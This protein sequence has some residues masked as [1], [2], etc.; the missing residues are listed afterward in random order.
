MRV[1]IKYLSL[2]VL[3]LGALVALLGCSEPGGYHPE[4]GDIVFQMSRSSQSLAIQ[5][6]TGS[7]YSHIG[8]VFVTN[9]EP[10]VLEAAR[11]V[12][13]KPLAGWIAQ[14]ENS[15]FVAK[16]LSA[17]DRILTA[18]TLEQMQE[19]GRSFEGRPY[20]MYFEWSDDSLYCS[21]LIWKIYSRCTGLEIGELQKMGELNLSD[22]LVKAK[23]VERF[24]EDLALN[25]TVI[26]PAA[27]FRSDL[28]KTVY[29]Q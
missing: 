12:S 19:L 29:E 28:L 11:T 2:L 3:A 4:D 16:R 26:S 13:L 10:Y 17:A 20:D 8:M 21:E 22:P 5:R 15:H 24:G 1:K 23:L 7:Q 25:E 9:G 18:A 27:M 6:A 14:G